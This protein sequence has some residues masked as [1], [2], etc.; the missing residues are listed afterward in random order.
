MTL[1]GFKNRLLRIAR[2]ALGTQPPE[3]NSYSQAG[4]DR[5]LWFL[6]H[7]LGIE[8]PRYIDVG[9][10]RPDVSSN[11]YLFYLKGSKG[12]CVEPDPSLFDRLQKARPDDQC[13]NVA[14]GYDGTREMDLFCFDEPSVNTLSEK[15]AQERMQGGQFKFVGLVKVPVMRLEEIIESCR[16]GIPQFVSLDAEGVDFKILSNFDFAA[17]PVP[18]WVVETVDYSPSASK[19]KNAGIIE[20]MKSHGFF[21]YADTYINTVFVDSNWYLNRCNA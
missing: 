4:E 21:V 20:L 10:N 1:R 3:Y 8:R 15:D 2:V 19:A 11:T 7:S 14:V 6:F 16:E 9:A 18:V 13:L 5:I 12:V 17:Y